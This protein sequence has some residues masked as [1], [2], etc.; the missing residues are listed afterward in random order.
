M[1]KY[2]LHSGLKGLRVFLRRQYKQRNISYITK[3][4]SLETLDLLVS[5]GI[6]IFMLYN[7][8]FIGQIDNLGIRVGPLNRNG[9]SM[10]S[11]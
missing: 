6:I 2:S 4:I 10:N 7:L 1:F 8:Y 9:G 11:L 5:N 3:N